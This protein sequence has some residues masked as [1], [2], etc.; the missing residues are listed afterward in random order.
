MRRKT[1]VWIAG[2]VIALVCLSLVVFSGSLTSGYH[3]MDCH[4][5]FT[6]LQQ[7]QERSWYDILAERIEWEQGMRF[8]PAWMMNT[9]L[10]T[11]LLGDDLFKQGLLQVAE[12]IAAGI[13]IYL[14]GIRLGWRR[15]ESLLLTALTLIGS[16]SAVFYQTLAV[17][18]TALL[19]LLIS[20]HLLLNAVKRKH[21]VEELPIS[22]EKPS[23]NVARL[24]LNAAKQCKDNKYLAYCGFILFSV[25]TALLKENFILI[26]P[27]GYLLY[28]REYSCR[29]GT[30]I[31]ETISKTAGTAGFLCALTVAG[32]YCVV[33]YAGTDFGYAGV[34]HNLLPYI[35]ATLY[36]YVGGGS[37]VLAAIAIIHLWRRHALTPQTW[38]LPLLFFAAIT[39]PQIAIYAKSN[40]IDRYLIPATL[41]CAFLAIF[42]F[43]ELKKHD[44]PLPEVI[45]R[46]IS[47]MLG[48][49][50]TAASTFLFSPLGKNAAVHF[51]F[52][53]Q[54]Q[55]LQQITSPSSMEYLY[56]SLSILTTTGLLIG[57]S[58]IIYSCMKPGGKI[59]IRNAS[60]LY[61]AG[62]LLLFL[63]NYGLA[64]AS[65]KRYAL[66]GKATE[67][68][69]QTILTNTGGGGIEDAIFIVS[70]PLSDVEGAQVGLPVY[71]KKHGRRNLCDKKHPCC[72]PEHI[73]AIAIF[74][75]MEQEFLFHKDHYFVHKDKWFI[76][77]LFRRYEFPGN[78]TLY[79]KEEN[80][81]QNLHHAKRSLI[82]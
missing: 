48:I 35:K 73:R 16:Q 24:L 17:E 66:R 4:E 28:F 22:A 69:C 67:A 65:C 43:R 10:E 53:M 1:G 20:W 63:L 15:G 18:T 26:L 71:L 75:G 27:A 8:R 45:Y 29:Y 56:T 33:K 39:V 72:D 64:F 74:P 5:Y 60:Q 49:V 57:I 6:C 3:F 41:G 21:Y 46:W 44:Y 19:T 61:L 70:S 50:M 47:L 2:T 13:L 37:V 51:A 79:I 9:I 59:A 25:I 82:P 77:D 78:F 68:F 31:A 62:L 14:L 38:A 32:L 7:L 76:D 80:Q 81:L 11:A 52:R 30:K 54:G 55:V 36:L 23:F 42:T 40:I 58:L 34:D 12:I